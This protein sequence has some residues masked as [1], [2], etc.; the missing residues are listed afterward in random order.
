MEENIKS[1]I[2][3]IISSPDSDLVEMCAAQHRMGSMVS[4]FYGTLI[5]EGVPASAALDL[6]K[7]MLWRLIGTPS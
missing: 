7:I 6:T 1:M 4:V 3:S 2:E 5:G